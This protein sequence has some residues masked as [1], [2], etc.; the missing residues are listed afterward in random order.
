[1]GKYNLKISTSRKKIWCPV[2]IVTVLSLMKSL[3]E[4][5]SYLICD[6]LYTYCCKK[7]E[8]TSVDI[9]ECAE[10]TVGYTAAPL[11]AQLVLQKVMSVPT[12]MYGCETGH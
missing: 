2:I 1:M 8:T 12:L 3:K 11:K 6:G 10:P 7:S 4:F 5:T 9:R